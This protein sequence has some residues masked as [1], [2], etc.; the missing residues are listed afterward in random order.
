MMM[1]MT[2]MIIRKINKWGSTCIVY[3]T[4]WITS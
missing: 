4:P 3:K 1:M 2:T